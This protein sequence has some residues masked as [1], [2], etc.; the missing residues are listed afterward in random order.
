MKFPDASN[1][2]SSSLSQ[3]T[4]QPSIYKQLVLYD[5]YF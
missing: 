3:E 1:N 4:H 5:I 2:V